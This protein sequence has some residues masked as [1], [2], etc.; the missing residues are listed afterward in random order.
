VNT[1]GIKID[2]EIKRLEVDLFSGSP[3]AL[4]TSLPSIAEKYRGFIDLFGY[5]INAGEMTDSSWSANILAFCTDRLNYEVY[6]RVMQTF[7]DIDWLESDLRE[8]FRYYAWHFPGNV[9]PGVY[10]CITGF[11]NSIIVGDSALGIG[12]DRYLG[13][14]S[15]YY[16]KLGIY[17]YQ[18]ARMTPENIV[19]DCIYAWITSEW[20]YD[21]IGYKKDD[22]LTNIIHEGKIMYC[23]KCMLPDMDN[24]RIFGF[25]AEQMDF[26]RSNEGGMWEYLIEKDIL[27]STDNLMITRL[28][29]EA[30]FTSIFTS[31]SPGRAAVWTGFRIV[32]RYMSNNRG[33]TLEELMLNSSPED[34]M[35]KARYSPE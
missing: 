27:F 1:S 10:T 12:L 24:E 21:S 33:M 9:M 15:D 28:T 3:A 6:T 29:G 14:D 31:E 22:V 25:T 8:A 23:V 2:I 26:C 30:P 16:P 19:N 17:N 11:N 7:P 20:N 18:A 5:V 32:E 35:E 4:V 13:K 34:I